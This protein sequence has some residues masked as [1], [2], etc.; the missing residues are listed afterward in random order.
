[1]ALREYFDQESLDLYFKDVRIFPFESADVSRAFGGRVIY[2]LSGQGMPM[3]IFPHYSGGLDDL[4]NFSL[5]E[6]WPEIASVDYIERY[7]I[8][9]ILLGYCPEMTVEEIRIVSVGE[10][11]I[12]IVFDLSERLARRGVAKV[13]TLKQEKA[14]RL[15]VDTP[16]IGMSFSYLP[17]IYEG[18]EIDE[19][20][21]AMMA[22]S[23]DAQERISSLMFHIWD[24]EEGERYEVKMK[25]E[26]VPVFCPG[27]KV[28]D[29]YK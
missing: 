14:N 26:V 27:A 24:V 15:I 23:F 2:S 16:C 9:D 28:S 20:A 22:M 21:P 17:K 3:M 12:E 6:E 11:L 4:I 29:D 7:G 1:M 5:M 18:E 19:F 13:L 25:K 8:E 10:G